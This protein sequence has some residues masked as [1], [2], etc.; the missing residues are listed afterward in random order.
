[1]GVI[2]DTREMPDRLTSLRQFVTYGGDG[3]TVQ[4]NCCELDVLV[5]YASPE[6]TEAILINEHR[7]AGLEARPVERLRQ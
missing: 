3:I 4:F 6:G 7:C 2:F 1:M 5:P